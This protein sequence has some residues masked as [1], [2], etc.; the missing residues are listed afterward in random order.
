MPESK[1]LKKWKSARAELGLD[2]V[3][4]YEVDLGNNVKVRAEFL[5]KH[6]G[7]R[8][9]TLIFTDSDEFWK[10]HDQLSKLHY[11]TSVLDEPTDE[12]D[13]LFDKEAFIEMLSEWE[14]TGS[15][16]EKPDWIKPPPN[17]DES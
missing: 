9:G 16:G 14:W 10:Y 15:E 13:V 2:I 7:G 17:N 3:A 4:P 12:A 5:V 11:G 1:L 6:F 8:N